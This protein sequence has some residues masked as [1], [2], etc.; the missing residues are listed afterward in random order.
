MTS[1]GR[2][3][4]SAAVLLIGAALLAGMMLSNPGYDRALRPFVTDVAAGTRGETRT[5][6]AAFTGWET[7]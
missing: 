4:A 1:V 5:F 7:A 2:A 6:A 3:L